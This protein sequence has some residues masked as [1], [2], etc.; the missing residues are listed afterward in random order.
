M[1]AFISVLKAGNISSHLDWEQC[2]SKGRALGIGP[3]AGLV[4]LASERGLIGP[5]EG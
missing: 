5:R 2:S 3:G 1:M 4:R